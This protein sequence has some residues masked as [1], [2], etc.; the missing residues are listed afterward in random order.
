MIS[1]LPFTFQ[2]AG[3]RQSPQPKASSSGDSSG[4]P[5]TRQ[6]TVAQSPHT[7]GSSTARLQ[8]GH[9]SASRFSTEEG[10]CSAGGRFSAGLP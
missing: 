8:V 2:A 10:F 1:S 9:H 5:H 4:V 3:L 6:I 7:S